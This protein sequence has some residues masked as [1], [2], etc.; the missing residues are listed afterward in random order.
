VVRQ[1][2]EVGNLVV[3]AGDTLMQDDSKVVGFCNGDMSCIQA[4]SCAQA[5]SGFQLTLNGKS[6]VHVS[7]DGAEPEVG[8]GVDAPSQ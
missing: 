5:D 7:E 1:E 6:E 4:S 8:K 3:N 2:V